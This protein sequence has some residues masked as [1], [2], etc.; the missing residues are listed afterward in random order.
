MALLLQPGS[1]SSNAVPTAPLG[2]PLIFFVQSVSLPIAMLFVSIVRV[3][4]CT[5]AVGRALLLIRPMGVHFRVPVLSC[6]TVCL[7]LPRCL[8]CWWSASQPNLWQWYVSHSARSR[9]P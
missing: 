2:L 3:V 8:V 6:Q 1:S 9:L 7:I 4:G 5:P